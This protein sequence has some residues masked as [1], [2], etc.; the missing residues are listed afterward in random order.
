MIKLNKYS[1]LNDIQDA[2]NEFQKPY[3]YHKILIYLILNSVYL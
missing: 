1:H 2:F 3:L